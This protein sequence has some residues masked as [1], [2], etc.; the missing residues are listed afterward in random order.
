MT[1]VRK[2]DCVWARGT[3]A[4]YRELNLNYL[5]HERK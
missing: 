5:I 4:Y 3:H 1:I 2:L